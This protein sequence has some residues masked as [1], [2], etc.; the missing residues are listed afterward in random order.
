MALNT[1]TDIR[2]EV[3]VRGQQSTTNGFITD[4]ILNNWLTE[5]HRWA[6]SYKK[7]P[8]T[9]GRI[10]T[11]FASALLTDEDGEYRGNYPEGWKPDSIRW[12]WIGGKRV[13]KMTFQAYKRFRED[14][15]NATDRVFTDYGRLYYVNPNIDLSGTIAL[16]GQ[17]TPT[18]ID[19][20]DDTAKTIFSDVD[21][22]G[23]EAIVEAM[24]S[25]MKS[26]SN[27]QNEAADH[28]TKAVSLLSG[29]WDRIQNEKFEYENNEN[30]IFEYIDVLAGGMRDDI[31]HRDRWF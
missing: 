18:N 2:T 17:Y 30:G 14:Q 19:V 3:L 9:E 29:V 4:T 23:N 1:I 31:I 21:E 28:M 10:S 7:W 20:T 12:M 26:R 5:K 6:A 24:V 11:T 27:I 13:K 16:W 15:P 25:M 8:F 22:D